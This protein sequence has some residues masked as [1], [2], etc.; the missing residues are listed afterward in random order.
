MGSLG[1]E[2]NEGWL[3]GQTLWCIQEATV[4]STVTKEQAKNPFSPPLPTSIF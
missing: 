2:M 4:L 3:Y 1:K